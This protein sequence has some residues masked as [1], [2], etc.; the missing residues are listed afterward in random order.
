[1]LIV[2]F[3]SVPQFSRLS[4]MGTKQIKARMDIGEI[5]EVRQ[6]KENATR[7]VDLVELVERMRAGQFELS[8]LTLPVEEVA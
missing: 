3:M 8:D 6:R 2:P 4:K 5:P 7:Y 1:M